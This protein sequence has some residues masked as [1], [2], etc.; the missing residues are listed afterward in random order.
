MP[1][2]YP[3]VRAGGH[4]LCPVETTMESKE[5]PQS[6]RGV[7]QASGTVTAPDGAPGG[8]GA[9]ILPRYTGGPPDEPIQPGNIELSPQAASDGAP[10]DRAPP[11]KEIAQAVSDAAH[12]DPIRNLAAKL[13]RMAEGFGDGTARSITKANEII[14]LAEAM[15]TSHVMN[16]ERAEQEQFGLGMS[17]KASGPDGGAA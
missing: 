14:A 13:A 9:R 6:L 10:Q 4:A 15:K 5:A 8:P 3:A 1:A 16:L 2:M 7:L 11:P 12:R 17:D